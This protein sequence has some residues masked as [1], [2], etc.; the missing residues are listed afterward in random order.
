MISGPERIYKIF[1]ID[2]TTRRIRELVDD[3]LLLEPLN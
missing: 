1:L 3:E 2:M